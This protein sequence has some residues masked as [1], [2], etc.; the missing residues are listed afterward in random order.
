M[1]GLEALSGK[2]GAEGKL[3]ERLLRV[4]V[5]TGFVVQKKIDDEG[6]GVWIWA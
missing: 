3:L 2:T 1:I 5:G 6:G 4:L